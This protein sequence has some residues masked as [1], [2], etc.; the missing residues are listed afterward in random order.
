MMEQLLAEDA[1]DKKAKGAAKSATSAKGKKARKRDG[2][3]PTA[4]TGVG[5]DQHALEAGD[6][7]VEVEVEDSGEAQVVLMPVAS[8][9]AAEPAAASPAATELAGTHPAAIIKTGAAT[10][11]VS[12]A[13]GASGRGRPLSSMPQQRCSG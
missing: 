12:V 11:P 8:P 10:A 1:E 13:I 6:A 7:G 9:P 4:S 3:S 5:T 2:E